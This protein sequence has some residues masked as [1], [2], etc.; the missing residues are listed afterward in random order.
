MLQFPDRCQH[1]GQI[2]QLHRH[3]AGSAVCTI[4]FYARVVCKQY[5]AAGSPPL[6]PPNLPTVLKPSTASGTQLRLAAIQPAQLVTPGTIMLCLVQ[7]LVQSLSIIAWSRTR[8]ASFT[9]SAVDFSVY[10][11]MRTG[12]FFVRTYVLKASKQA[13]LVEPPQ[14]YLAFAYISSRETKSKQK[15]SRKLKQLVI[16]TSSLKLSVV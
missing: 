5:A 3:H 6:T 10:L 7:L 16:R 2:G 14:V 13:T 15:L 8:A 12:M 4:T 9:A 1:P 11:F